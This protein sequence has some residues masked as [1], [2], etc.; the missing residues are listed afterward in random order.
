MVLAR[1]DRASMC[2]QGLS[3]MSHYFELNCLLGTII[4]H[5]LHRYPLSTWSENLP[6]LAQQIILVG[7]LW[8]LGTIPSSAHIASFAIVEAAFIAGG[9]N[10]V[11]GFSCSLLS[12]WCVLFRIA[13]TFKAHVAPPFARQWLDEHLRK[14]YTGTVFCKETTEPN[15]RST[16]ATPR[17]CFHYLIQ[18]QLWMNFTEKSIGQLSPITLGLALA[19]NGA[20]VFTTLVS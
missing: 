2:L 16:N 18:I 14:L 13:Q 3:L 19:G 20:R 4:Y 9:G 15:A 6:L 8:T 1:V 17:M 12:S 11:A 7:L 10:A 5:R